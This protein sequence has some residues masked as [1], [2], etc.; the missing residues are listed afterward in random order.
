MHFYTS[1]LA[2]WCD[3]NPRVEKW[4]AVDE[5]YDFIED[6]GLAAKEICRGRLSSPLSDLNRCQWARQTINPRHK[7]SYHLS[8]TRK[9]TAVVAPPPQNSLFR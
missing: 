7:T 3:N 2:R 1:S 9:R 5:D 6:E 4:M 8:Y